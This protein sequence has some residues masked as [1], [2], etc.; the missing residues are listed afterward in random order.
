MTIPKSEKYQAQIERSL[1]EL[2]YRMDEQL[3]DWL[4]KHEL[5]DSDNFT[6]Q[7]R[8]SIRAVQSIEQEWIL[9]PELRAELSLIHWEEE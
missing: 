2:Y 8:E 4:P 3:L 5:L 6:S 1:A 7:Q 9:D